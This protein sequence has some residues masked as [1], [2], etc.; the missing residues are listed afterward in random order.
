MKPEGFAA[1]AGVV[2]PSP[3]KRPPAGLG[4]CASCP[5]GVED[6][7][8]PNRFDVGAAVGVALLF[9]SVEL[10][11]FPPKL[12]RLGV[13]EAVVVAGFAPPNSDDPPPVVWLLC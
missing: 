1:V 6:W 11:V 5:L 10:A 9:A 12:N 2:L 13:E 8:P 7:F 3:P 4:V